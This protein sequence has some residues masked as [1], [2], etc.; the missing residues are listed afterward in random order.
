[1]PWII[2]SASE[3]PV[4]VSDI[5]ATFTKGQ[6]RDV[7][8]HGG[9]NNAERSNELKMLIMKGFL[10][11]IR[12]DPPSVS[13]VTDVGKMME[14]LSKHLEEVHQTVHSSAAESNDKMRRIE[15]A[16]AE[17][18]RELA[19]HKRDVI[20]MHQKILDEFR[21]FADKHPLQT[22]TIV[23]AIKNIVVERGVIAD[24]LAAIQTTDSSD[25]D[26]KTEERL[27]A[28]RDR[29]L[30]KNLKNLGKTMSESSVGD[31]EASLKALE[32]MDLP[33]QN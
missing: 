15:E 16:Q 7:D 8:L 5:N 25:A 21:A 13:P 6:I 24:K 10:K 33:G 28:I 9:R 32:D 14:P 31:I 17:M 19:D 22:Q 26:I 18:R 30:E 23:Q 12:K 1:M 27:L 20:D 2:Q 4:V 3:G 11:E 29:K